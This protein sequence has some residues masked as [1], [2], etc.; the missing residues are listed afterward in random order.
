MN[1]LTAMRRELL[2]TPAVAAIA[3]G[4]I[5]KHEFPEGVDLTGKVAILVRLVGGWGRSTQTCSYPRVMVLAQADPSRDLSGM[6]IVENGDD[7]ALAALAA[8]EKVMHRP[9][10]ETVIWG[11]VQGLRILGSNKET[12]PSPVTRPNQVAAWWQQVYDIKTG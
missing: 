4:G 8:V 12:E 9:I 11:G 2:A 3:T 6:K 7:R 1:I 5:H 10:R